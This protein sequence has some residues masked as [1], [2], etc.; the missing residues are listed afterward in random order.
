[1]HSVVY[2]TNLQRFIVACIAVSKLNGTSNI[3]GPG[4]HLLRLEV[5]SQ[6]VH[7]QMV[8]VRSVRLLWFHVQ[9]RQLEGQ[10]RRGRQWVRLQGRV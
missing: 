3:P 10:R 6:R 4:E 5:E 1:V 9:I 7:V 8:Y 2:I